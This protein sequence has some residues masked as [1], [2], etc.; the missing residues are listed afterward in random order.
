MPCIRGVGCPCWFPQSESEETYRV[1]IQQFCHVLFHPITLF[2]PP[3]EGDWIGVRSTS[4]WRGDDAV[5][6]V[7][8]GWHGTYT[9]RRKAP[10]AGA[11]ALASGRGVGQWREAPERAVR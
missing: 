1:S 3:S 7:P 8:G 6:G 2:R 5:C 4:G 10:L 9:A 11:G